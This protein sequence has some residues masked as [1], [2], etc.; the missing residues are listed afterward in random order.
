MRIWH[1]GKFLHDVAQ[2]IVSN[3]RAP[4][5]A[6]GDLH[7][8]S[9][10]TAVCERELLRLVDRYGKDTVVEAMQ[11]TQDYVERTV[12]AQIRELPRGTW[13]TVDYLDADPAQG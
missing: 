1:R 2:L 7:A 12:L 3:T 9:E 5:I 13:E 6:M 11:E 8:Q 10:A 4:E